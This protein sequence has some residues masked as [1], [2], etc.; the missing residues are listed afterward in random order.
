MNDVCVTAEKHF[1][2]DVFFNDML[3]NAK[4]PMIKSEAIANIIV[5]SQYNMHSP[6]ILC[7]T[8]IGRLPRYL[9]KYR[10][11]GFLVVICTSQRLAN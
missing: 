9:S 3:I 7:E 2:H 11:I 5:K 10:P 1:P 4:K 6:L 8:D